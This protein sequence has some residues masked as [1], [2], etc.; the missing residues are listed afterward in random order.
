MTYDNQFFGKIIDKVWK[1][2]ASVSQFLSYN[3]G[4]CLGY[5]ELIL[6]RHLTRLSP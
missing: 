5:I 1:F 3:K 6:S 4:L 2:N